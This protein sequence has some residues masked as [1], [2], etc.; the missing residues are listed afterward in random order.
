MGISGGG[1]TSFAQANPGQGYRGVEGAK[2]KTIFLALCLCLSGATCAA[3][4][5]IKEAWDEQLI[6]CVKGGD[7]GCVAR[8]LAAGASAD[9]TDKDGVS[10]LSF[11]AEG[12]SESVVR[13]LLD[14]GADVNRD[15]PGGTIPLC[16]AALFGREEI[17]STLL[18]AGA[19][20]N[21]ECDGDHGGTPLTDAL[22]AAMLVDMPGELTEGDREG[23][24]D[25][26]E[27]WH[28][29]MRSPR[30]SFL[31]IARLL[32]ERGAD[33]NVVA[34]CD[35]GETALMYAAMS[36]NVEMVE[37]LLAHGA[38]VN[39]GGS[40]LAQL[41][42]F[43]YE[44]EKA[45]WLALPALS[46][47][48]SAMLAWFEKTQAARAKIRQLLKAA[49]AKEPEDE[50]RADDAADD[51]APE[52]VADEAFSTTIKKN[53]LED[54]GRLVKAYEGHP[55]AASVLAG[56]LRTAVIYDRPEML[57]LLLAHG[58]DPN[59]GRL[60]P[61]ADAARDGKPEMVLM[62]LEA[63]ADLNAADEDG[64]T[65]LDAAESWSGSSEGHDAVIELLKSRGA[66]SG[67]QK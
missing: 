25:A 61:L 46:K 59:V 18:G 7:A 6:A 39:N 67:K 33:V 10:A 31:A 14:A 41:R 49:G 62:L 20:I 38:R 40:V 64:R 63:G 23:D 16:R 56:A 51:E 43:E 4:G 13:L 19:K 35:V 52:Q 2:M 45:K 15:R 9:A 30:E 3:Q 53:D 27:K 8:A 50:E 26:D 47:E 1:G 44:S 65:A 36:A 24:G 29:V 28:R 34:K 60:R 11:A 5:K 55:L 57:R 54:L 17:V 12:T 32:V 66:K 48:Q 58:A 21:V 22:L 37:L 42:E